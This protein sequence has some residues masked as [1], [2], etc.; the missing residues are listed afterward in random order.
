MLLIPILLLI[1]WL[2]CFIEDKKIK[3]N[4]IKVEGIIKS[5]DEI[6]NKKNLTTDTIVNIQFEYNG[7]K[8]LKLNG[9]TIKT[10]NGKNELILNGTVKNKGDK[11]ECIYDTKRNLL[12]SQ[13]NSS[14]YHIIL[15]F[16]IIIAIPI[17]F[18][19]YILSP[20]DTND[21]IT[22]IF[23]KLAEGNNYYIELLII[24][25]IVFI[26]PM[27]FLI[28]GLYII[29]KSRYDKEYQKVNATVKSVLKASHKA[30][31]YETN[32]YCTVFEYEYNN[33]KMIYST[34]EFTTDEQYKIGDKTKLFI[35]KKTGEASEKIDENNS[36]KGI[37]IM[38]IVIY[39]IIVLSQL[40]T[41][42]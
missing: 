19:N 26:L 20:S 9:I 16:A 21:I 4:G 33:Q 35:N 8:E 7:T 6:K 1:I 23:M 41:S 29:K 39:I 10:T 14:F 36:Y 13:N 30:D 28:I 24:I 22:K 34:H 15:I 5:I 38:L 11:V 40:I 32:L 27:P 2:I 17:I 18:T 31:N 25:L 3:K 12:F 37:G 42:S